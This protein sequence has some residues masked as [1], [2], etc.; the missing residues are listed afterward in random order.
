MMGKVFVHMMFY[1][2]VI[3]SLMLESEST[4]Q[5]ATDNRHCK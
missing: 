3:S 1:R 4:K 5:M 2:N